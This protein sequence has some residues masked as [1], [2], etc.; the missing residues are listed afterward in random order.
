MSDTLARGALL[1]T[2]VYHLPNSLAKRYN[3][4]AEGIR[5]WSKMIPSTVGLVSCV[6]GSQRVGRRMKNGACWRTL[7]LSAQRTLGELR[8]NVH[9]THGP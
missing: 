6:P 1:K 4:L 2:T 9:Q 7:V 5:A 3:S 8:H